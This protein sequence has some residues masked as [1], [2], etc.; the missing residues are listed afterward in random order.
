MTSRS[1][2]FL[3]ATRGKRWGFRFLRD[4]GLPDPLPIYENAFA[5]VGGKREVCLRVGG[6]VVLRFPDPEGRT[7]AAGRVIPHSFVIFPPLADEV[8]SLDDGLRLVWAQVSAEFAR[9]WDAP[10]AQT[11]RG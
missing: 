8:H 9:D 11:E 4:G 7:D 1:D 10:S 6:D 2:P 3:W 5:G